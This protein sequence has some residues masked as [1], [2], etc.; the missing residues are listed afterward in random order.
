MCANKD[1]IPGMYGLGASFVNVERNC[2]SLLFD[3]LFTL[4]DS[5]KILLIINDNNK[6]CLGCKNYDV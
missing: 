2:V 1:N 4:F 6:Y 5:S 3:L